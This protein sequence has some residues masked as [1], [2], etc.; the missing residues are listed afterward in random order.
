MKTYLDYNATC[1]PRPASL[2][3]MAAISTLPLNASSVHAYGREAKKHL[4][5]S[6]KIIAES[7]S[8]FVDELIFTSSGS[9]SNHLA[10]SNSYFASILVASTEHSSVLKNATE[11]LIIPVDSQG[12]V[13]LD[14]LHELLKNAPKPALVS[15]ML[16]NNETGV[17]QP[18]G[19]IAAICRKF[20][21]QFH[22]DAVQGL[23]KI[24]VDVNLI[25]ADYLSI[26]AHKVGGPLGVAALVVRDKSPFSPQLKGGGQEKNR[27]AGTEP[28]ALIAGF[29]AAVEE[30]CA[31]SQMNKIKK[32]RS[33]FDVLEAQVLQLGGAVFGE[34]SAR[35]PNTSCVAMPGK[36]AEVQL[37]HF[38]LLGFAISAGSACSSG[39]IEPSH[40]LNAMG[41][42]KNQAECAIRIS[43]G[44]NTTPEEI[45]T[46]SKAWKELAQRK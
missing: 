7:I 20:K 29:A 9:E 14:Q 8:C 45:T 35:L 38:D 21:T 5:K 18:V 31:D 43:A 34:K 15:V 19:E 37:M 27:R 46:F 23:G 26:S 40:V 39:R 4:E 33:Y 32:I 12:V 6:R 10:L 11:A 41:V 17:I 36:S 30:A 24:P 42:A 44:W 28:I 22:C 13:R 16:A 2:Q 1:L 3:A 25:G